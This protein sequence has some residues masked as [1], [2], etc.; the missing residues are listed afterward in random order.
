MYR[1]PHLLPLVQ[2]NLAVADDIGALRHEA[3]VDA[4]ERDRVVAAQLQAEK[5]IIGRV[6][7]SARVC[8]A[9]LRRSPAR[10]DSRSPH[11]AET[12]T[13]AIVRM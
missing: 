12:L 3:L 5:A 8:G 1:L 6:S 11:I 7:R 9:V 4:E 10:T 13:F 2:R